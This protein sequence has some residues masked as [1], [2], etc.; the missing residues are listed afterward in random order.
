MPRPGGNQKQPRNKPGK[1]RHHRPGFGE[2]AVEQAEH[3]TLPTLADQAGSGDEQNEQQHGAASS[4][5]IRLAMWDLG[6]CDKKRCTGELLLQLQHVSS[7]RA[8]R[9]AAQD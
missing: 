7:N 5:S 8:S 2:E 3:N 6:Q 9:I 1:G 4:S